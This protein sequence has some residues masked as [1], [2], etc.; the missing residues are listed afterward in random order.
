MT[1]N[2]APAVT[3][4]LI[5]PSDD[6]ELARILRDTMA[7]F[8]VS[9]PGTAHADPEVDHLSTA[10]AS[11]GSRYFVLECEGVPV[12]GGGIA[13]LRGGQ[14]GVCE[15]QKMYLRPHLRG[16][17]L[18]KLLLMTCLE[19]AREMGYHTCYLETMS[20]MAAARGLYEK[21]GFKL[22]CEPMGDTGHGKCD[23]WYARGL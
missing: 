23:T 19:A 11:A 2:D 1:T 3:L 10:F 15:L 16:R 22:A 6:P 5:E 21:L 7:E 4:R 20:H 12:G 14:P 13:P 8:G 9:G 17:G 18:G